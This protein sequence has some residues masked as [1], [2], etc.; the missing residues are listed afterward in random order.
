MEDGLMARA[1]LEAGHAI[2]YDDA[3]CVHHSHEYAAA[4]TR[5]RAYVDGVINAEWLDRVAVVSLEE[6]SE[7]VERQ[8]R[9]DRAALEQ[10][11]LAGEPLQNELREA[12]ALR[13]SYYQGLY[14]GGR[15][16]RRVRS[17]KMLADPFLR[18][19]HVVAVEQGNASARM[20]REAM[21][22]RGH[23]FEVCEGSGAALERL[24]QA[25]PDLMHVEQA[26]R[27][28]RELLQ[29][30]RQRPLA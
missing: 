26:A 18:I 27:P 17:T 16:T 6:V 20:L 22:A 30:A 13:R 9:R 23:A 10:A 3:A 24:S 19:L 2:V 15:S 1:L 8:L 12:Q 4:R 29:R 28:S 14:E 25:A 21:G 7:L 11:G 5:A